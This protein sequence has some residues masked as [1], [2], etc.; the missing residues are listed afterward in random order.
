MFPHVI[1]S[2][3]HRPHPLREEKKGLGN[4]PM[5]GAREQMRKREREEG[6]AKVGANMQLPYKARFEAPN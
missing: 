2:H 1:K 4:V 3:H 6:D 5:R